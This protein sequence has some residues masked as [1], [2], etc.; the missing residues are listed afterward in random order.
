MVTLY[1]SRAVLEGCDDTVLSCVLTCQVA[2]ACLC[3]CGAGDGVV[4]SRKRWRSRVGDVVHA[5]IQRWRATVALCHRHLRQPEGQSLSQLVMMVLAGWS[6]FSFPF[7]PSHIASSLL[8]PSPSP[9]LSPVHAFEEGSPPGKFLIFYIAFYI[10]CIL[11]YVKLIFFIYG[12]VVRKYWKWRN[13]WV[14]AQ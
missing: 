8:P 4:D 14:F 2:V 7:L 5:V 13:A 3:C 6:P 12:F 1:V 9:S 11:R 10:Y